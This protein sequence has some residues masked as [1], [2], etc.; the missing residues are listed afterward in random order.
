MISMIASISLAPIQAMADHPYIGAYHSG[1]VRNASKV[2]VA[3]NFGGTTPS[4]FGTDKWLAV[5]CWS[6]YSS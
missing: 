3:T 1:S 5:K 2:L 6:P 4:N